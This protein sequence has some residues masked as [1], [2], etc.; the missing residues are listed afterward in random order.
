MS[1]GSRQWRV[2]TAGWS[3]KSELAPFAGGGSA[4]ERYASVFNCVEINSSFYRPHKPETYAR[5]ADSVPEHFRF[6]VKLPKAISHEA[7][8]ALEGN[9]LER[10]A[11]E[12]GM[13]GEKLG[14]V[15]VQLPPGLTFEA[16]R[17]GQFFHACSKAWAAATL[18]EPRHRSWFQPDALSLMNEANVSLVGADPAILP[19]AGAPIVNGGPAYW[20][21]HGSP[22]MYYSAYTD[23][24]IASYADAMRISAA[25]EC[26]C[27]FDNTAEGA[28]LENA[29]SMHAMLSAR[30]AQLAGH[31][32]RR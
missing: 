31:A 28:A 13:L 10:F 30:D 17:A 8:L 12:L 20:R 23:A 14:A 25:Q 26:W 7:R 4:L 9:A 6:S 1:S 15:L 32:E 11:G 24:Q 2:G 18:C 3:I 16:D 27:I 22:R 19:Q 29:L 21:L 5:W